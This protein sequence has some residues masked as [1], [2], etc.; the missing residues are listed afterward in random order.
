MTLAGIYRQP[1]IRLE[2]HQRHPWKW[3]TLAENRWTHIGRK[4]TLTD[5]DCPTVT[6]LL[7]TQLLNRLALRPVARFP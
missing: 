1:V 4:L 7:V 6:L 3:T 5:F 2:F